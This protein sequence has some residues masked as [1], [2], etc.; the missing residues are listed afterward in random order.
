MGMI[1]FIKGFENTPSPTARMVNRIIGTNIQ[2][3]GS[4]E[5]FSSSSP[6]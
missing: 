6:S 3:E 1:K 4:K 5:V 2:P